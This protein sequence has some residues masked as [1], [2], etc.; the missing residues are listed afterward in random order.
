M[1]ATFIFI[2]RMCLGRLM[3]SPRKCAWDWGGGSVQVA[4]LTRSPKLVNSEEGRLVAN[5]AG[6]T[7]HYGMGGGIRRVH[8]PAGVCQD[9][10]KSGNAQK[11]GD[12][13]SRRQ[14]IERGAQAMGRYFGRWPSITPRHKG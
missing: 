4:A 2:S 11:D 6:K 8:S 3:V 7:R 1:A 13:W 9:A 12:A 5:Q 10:S 14:A